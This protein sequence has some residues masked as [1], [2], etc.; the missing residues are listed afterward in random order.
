MMTFS[1]TPSPVCVRTSS[2]NAALVTT[3]KDKVVLEVLTGL[4]DDLQAQAETIGIGFGV[5]Q[6]G[7]FGDGRG[8]DRDDLVSGVGGEG[9]HGSKAMS[10]KPDNLTPERGLATVAHRRVELLGVQAAGEHGVGDDA[11]VPGVADDLHVREPSGTEV[12]RR[13][14]RAECGTSH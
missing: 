2:V 5:A 3:S 7:Q 12:L 10:G 9:A 1:V 11:R 14:R 6:R 8:S 13:A 4:A